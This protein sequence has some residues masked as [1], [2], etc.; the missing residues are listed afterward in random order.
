M[1]VLRT[2]PELLADALLEAHPDAEPFEV[3]ADRLAEWVRDAGADPD[4]DRVMVAALAAW[5][6]RRR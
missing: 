6:A 3:P 1:T 2:D 5:E 4:D